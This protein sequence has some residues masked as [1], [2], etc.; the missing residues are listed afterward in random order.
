[1]RLTGGR[2]ARLI[3]VPVGVIETRNPNN[4]RPHR[5]VVIYFHDG[6]RI[7]VIPSKSGLPDDP[8]W[9][10]NAL[11]DPDVRFE[12]EPFRAEPVEDET[13]KTRIWHLAQQFY[14]PNITY[15]KRAAKTGRV[16]PILQLVPRP[17]GKTGETASESPAPM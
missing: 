13:S 3:P 6:D 5:R 9:Y 1:M 17:Q 16:I 8:Y 7:I 11:A 12:S 10:L 15:R 14:P 4:N 2:F